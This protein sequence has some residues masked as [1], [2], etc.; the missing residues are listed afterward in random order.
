MN[1]TLARVLKEVISESSTD[2]PYVFTSP[3]TGKPYT[4]IKTSFPTALKKIGLQGF[5]FHMLRHIWCSR[6]CELGIDEVTIM[7]L[8]GWKTR[9]M[10]NRYSHPSMDHEREALEKLNKVPLILPLDE[11][12]ASLIKFDNKANIR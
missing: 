5:T 11:K 3:K 10:I 12:S 2:S 9:S 7:E 4:D 6:M 8:G 1:E